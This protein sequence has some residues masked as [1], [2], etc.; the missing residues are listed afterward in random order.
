MEKCGLSR[1][2]LVT[3]DP[4]SKIVDPADK[5]TALIF[6]DAATATLL[7]KNAIFA[8]G[9]FDFGTDGSAGEAL[10]ILDNGHLS[11]NGRAVFDFTARHVPPSVERTLA[12]NGIPIDHVDSFLL[13]SGSRYI[14]DTL[15]RRLGIAAPFTS[16]SIGNAVSSSIPL[17]LEAMIDGPERL[18]FASGFGVGLGWASTMLSKP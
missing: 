2:V 13:H 14:V 16:S 6:G 10:T 15:S 3:A 18:V 1:G 11:M 4:Y 12:L 5:N 8:L 9:R 17:M 7:D